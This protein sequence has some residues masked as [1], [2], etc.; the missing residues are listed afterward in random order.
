MNKKIDSLGDRAKR[1]E[2][3]TR[4][5][6]IRRMPAILR[7]DGR[8]F[9]SFTR[10]CEKP[11]DF[12]LSD[13]MANTT[14][15]LIDSIQGAVFGFTQSDEITILLRDYDKLETDAFF[16]GNI[17][18]I[19]SVSAAMASTYFNKRLEFL[20]PGLPLAVFDARVFNVPREDVCNVILWRQNDILRNSIQGLG[21][22]HLGHKTI[23]GLNNTEVTKLLED[24]GIHLHEIPQHFRYGIAASKDGIDLQVPSFVAD[25]EYIEK[26][27]YLHE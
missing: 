27:V 5:Y 18:K 8:S 4:Q 14:K 19:V 13:A 24:K 1:Y 11:F 2:D 23:Q 15:Y 17:Q 16:D 6:L 12:V 26:H 10:W 22:Y 9:S 3:V 25:R 20:K 7:L 21:Q